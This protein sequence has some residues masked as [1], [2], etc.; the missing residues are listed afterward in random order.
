MTHLIFVAYKYLLE[1]KR[2]TL[3]SILGVAI[4][5][6]A[7]I[8]MSAIMLGFQKYFITQVIDIEPHISIKP[9][10][11]FDE[12][13]II[14]GLDPQGIWVVE[15]SKPKEKDK[16]IGWRELT[17]EIEKRKDISGVAPQL[18]VRGL[19]KYGV[20]EKAVTILGI[21]PSLEKKASS[22]ERFLEKRDLS[23]LETN[24]NSIILGKLIA[25][26][27]GIKEYGKKVI[28]VLPNGGLHLLKVEDF[29]STGITNIDDSRVYLHIRALQSFT[30]RM[31]E[32]NRII[33]RVKEVDL[34]EKIARELQSI[35]EYQ[36]E[37][38][39]RAY[40]NFL[41]IFKL[42]NIITYLVVFSVLLV[43]AFGIFNIIMMTVLEKKKDIA[44]LMAMG[45]SQGDILK[46]FL[47]KGL[48]IGVL[49][50]LLGFL[51][52]YGLQEYLV[53][54]DLETEGLI[55]S[56]GFL[57]YRSVSHY[58][59]ALLF[60]LFFSFLSSFYPAYRA[61]KLN[62]VEIFRSS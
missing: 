59:Y 6:T 38:W 18:M 29:L 42:Q 54:V 34:A 4:G 43:S 36:V 25:R 23:V 22:L 40:L 7:Y 13:R 37:S 33:I 8:V 21:D 62:P 17:R 5:V 39:K 60:S 35:T 26:D 31:D 45:Y 16:I 52:A 14:V 20:K 44:I 15:G 10:E 28:L 1:R 11:V 50:S 41:K 2:Q 58:L 57:L 55:R 9:K 48:I 56:K 32:V 24:K 51:L 46:L 49:G 30:G 19:V 47:S 12:K 3:I 53:R 61:S 27:L